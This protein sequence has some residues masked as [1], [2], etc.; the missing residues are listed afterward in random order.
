M[1]APTNRS[2]A[3]L[4]VTVPL[5]LVALL[6]VAATT[7]SSGVTERRRYIPRSECPDS[8]AAALN[9]TVTVLAPAVAAGMFLA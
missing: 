1:L 3:F 5:L 7:T 9:F 8:I 6:P 2:V 4:V